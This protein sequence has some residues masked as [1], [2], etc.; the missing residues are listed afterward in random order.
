MRTFHWWTARPGRGTSRLEAA[1]ATR[2]GHAARAGGARLAGV[3]LGLLLGAAE[4][5][6]VGEPHAIVQVVFPSMTAVDGFLADF[7]ETEL[8]TERRILGPELAISP[9][10]LAR[11]QQLGYPLRAIA[12]LDEGADAASAPPPRNQQKNSLFTFQEHVDTLLALAARY[13]AITQLTVLNQTPEGRPIY[14]MKVSDN[15][16]SD[17]DEPVGLFVGVHHADEAVGVD[18]VINGLRYL[19][20]GYETNPTTA[21]RVDQNELWFVPLPNADGW[22]MLESGTLSAWRKNKR[23]NNGNQAFDTGDGVDLN[24]NYA[25][26]WEMGSPIPGLPTY[27][28]PSPFSEVEIQGLRDLILATRPSIALTYHQSGEVVIIPWTW[29]GVPTPDSLTYRAI[30]ASLAGSIPRLDGLPFGWYEDQS[31]AGF[32]D[33]WMYATC[34][35]FCFTVEVTTPSNSSIPAARANN[36]SGILHA[37]DRLAGPQ[38]TGLV[39]DLVSGIPIG[40]EVDVLEVDTSALVARTCEP[41]TGR[42]RR[43]IVPGTYSL[44]VRAPGHFEQ[45]LPVTVGTAGPAVVDVALADSSL[46]TAV[47]RD[48]PVGPSLSCGPNPARGS[49]VVRYRA[50][51]PAGVR[52]AIHDLSG[53]RI[54]TWTPAAAAEGHLVWDGTDAAGH[55]VAAGVYLVRLTEGRRTATTRLVWLP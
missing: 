48:G 31:V 2:P 42:H 30:A 55:R 39:V 20:E 37:I 19:L 27:R 54:R 21:A 28:G 1:P 11:L 43:L 13:P 15:A 5:R 34:G 35:G 4:V 41:G 14:A 23:D 25:F 16:A 44:R 46:V 38:I 12:T 36:L 18:I 9:A 49:A 26:N 17:E 32:M 40:A 33:D 52:V 7:P 47:D 8:R 24:R 22:M 51:S 6:A 10:G 45:L 50:E 3:L 29:N 53:R